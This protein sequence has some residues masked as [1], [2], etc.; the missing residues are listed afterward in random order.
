MQRK[1]QVLTVVSLA[2]FMTSLDL[3]I[4]NV[5]FP[6]IRRD[7]D[8]ASLSGLSWVL[9]AYAIVF[10]ALMVPAGRWADAYG[11]KRVF[12]AGVLLFVAASALCAA[13]PSVETLVAARVL[14]A[15]GGA[16][17][18][19]AS[20]GLLLPE[21]PPAQRPLAIAIWAAVG[22]VA[23]AAGPP[24]G[25]LL[26]AIDWRWV[27]FVNL[28]IGLAI[29]AF[30]LHLLREHRDESPLRPDVL[31]A[32]A[33]VVGVGALIGAIVE[34]PEWGWG[35]TRVLS[36][37][38]LAALGLAV[39]AAR[40]RR[41]PAP[42]V[43]A[44]MVRLRSFSVA[45]TACVVYYAGFGAMLL[46]SVLVLT[47]PWGE[48]A[49]TAGLMIAPGPA[50]AAITSVPGSK[51]AGRIGLARTGLLGGVVTSLGAVWWIT[52]LTATPD[53]AVDFLPGMVVGGLGVGLSLPLFTAAA[54]SELDA[55]RFSTG[56]AVV[57]MA[58]QL[59]TALGV[60]AVVAIAGTGTA[61]GDF[62]GVW[63]FMIAAALTAGT[64]LLGLGGAFDRAGRQAPQAAREHLGE[65]VLG[66]AG[67]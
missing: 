66:G 19:P 17:L 40:S 30:G 13:A 14:Q 67:V 57:T 3:F 8:G 51:L 63:L 50:T 1:W 58:R 7:F 44:A 32:G 29:M 27:F 52:H 43:D 22:G 53:F 9:S 2:V 24:I 12:S 49:L 37:F 34:G 42:V 46:S 28:P 62:D 4:V 47:G 64:I 11:R 65:Q 38:G 56:A 6:D 35:D 33:L 36:A 61:V 60:A 16:L 21:F 18:M 20:L 25:G 54:T 45:T 39:V 48:D 59:G 31:G 5:A 41:H 15:A 55:A 26:V 23:A 10:A